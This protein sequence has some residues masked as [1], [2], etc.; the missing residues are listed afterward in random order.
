MLFFAAAAL[1]LAPQPSPQHLESRASL[2]AFADAFDQAQINKDAAALKRMI[3]DDLI[4]IDGS[5]ARKDKKAFIAGWLAPGDRYQPVTLVD[6]T[7]TPLS[8]D[9]W[10]VGAEVTLRGVSDGKPFAS[11][12]RFSDIF[13]RRNGRWRAVYIQVTRIPS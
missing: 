13:K 5:G 1:A 6:R 8:A 12:F 9:A 11:R 3:S 2:V 7:I 10:I 4:F